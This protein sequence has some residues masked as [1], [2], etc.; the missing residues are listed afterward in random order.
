M[1]TDEGRN[2]A[3][4]E[5][6]RDRIA[7]T[8][9]EHYAAG[10]LEIAEL[11][12]RLEIVLAARTMHEAAASLAGLPPSPSGVPPRRRWWS[13]RHGE[14]ELPEPGWVPTLERFRD[15]STNR[16]MRVWLDPADGSRRYV[17]ESI[18]D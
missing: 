18:R 12:R 11:D 6:D 17:A 10:R 16:L 4:S 7:A 14:H 3:A 2:L 1:A 5:A 15:P 8:L 9:G 13:R